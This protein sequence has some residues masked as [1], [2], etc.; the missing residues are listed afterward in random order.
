MCTDERKEVPL[1]K[2]SDKLSRSELRRRACNIKLVL[3]DC[4]GVL[5]DTGVYF[6]K[7]GEVMKRFSIRDGMGTEL[8]RT[9][10][11][12]TGYITGETSPGLKKRAD[13]LK[14]KHLY[15]GVDN[16]SAELK[17]ILSKTKF[18]AGQLAY[19]GDDVNDLEIL[20]NIGKAGLTATP[21]DGMP[22]VKKSVHYICKVRGGQGAFRDFA[23]WILEL[24]S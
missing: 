23:D 13:K 15:L 3:S 4:D 16:K 11:I 20:S 9:A 22:V 14:I 24:R 10:G 21:S 1:P 19:I 12:E 7:A 2:I 5:T 17:K 8:L 18:S 6:S